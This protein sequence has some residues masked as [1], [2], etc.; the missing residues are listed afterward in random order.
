MSRSRSYSCVNFVV[1]YWVFWLYIV[2]SLVK[3]EVHWHKIMHKH[4]LFNHITIVCARSLFI[5]LTVYVLYS[6][7]A[8]SWLSLFAVYS[9]VSS[10]ECLHFAWIHQTSSYTLIRTFDRRDENTNMRPN[11]PPPF[12][13]TDID[14]NVWMHFVCATISHVCIYMYLFVDGNLL[15]L[16]WWVSCALHLTFSILD[17]IFVVVVALS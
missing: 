1:M 8:V 7:R 11:K 12:W 14:C 5:G 15:S 13:F 2:S 10:D 6:V 9:T 17:V 4:L 16:W 3:M